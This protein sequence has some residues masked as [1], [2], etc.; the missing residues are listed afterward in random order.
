MAAREFHGVISNQWDTPIHWVQDDCDSGQ[1]QDPWYPSKLTG[2]GLINP[3]EDKEWRSESAGILTGTSGWSLWRINVST[4]TDTPHDEF[5]QV[6]W[7]IPFY[8]APNITY[9]VFRSDPRDAFRD[10]NPPVLEIIPVFW[11]EDGTESALA[12]AAEI[13]PY[14]FAIPVSFFFNVSFSTHPRIKFIV[15]QRAGAHVQ[16]PLVFEKSSLN[17][18]SMAMRAFQLRAEIAARNNFVGGFP[19]FYEATYGLDHVGG[20]IFV[21]ST[22]AEW[23]DVSVAELGNPSLEDFGE[24]MRATNAY[25]SRNGFV[26]GFPNFFHANYGSGIVCGTVLLNSTGA[27]WRD[28]PLSELGNPSLDD[29]ETRFRATQDYATRNG[30]V[31]GFPNLF[32][33]ETVEVSIVTGQRKRKT[34][35]GTILLKQSF[36]EWRDVLLFRGP[37]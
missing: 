25:A 9:S 13:A 8:G 32:H 12:Q 35:C 16:S 11:S 17:R 24:R 30:F 33:A 15:R 14:V 28:V 1:W 4:L 10:P 22:V 29:F 2:A 23:R 34:V 5:I 21:K 31:G 20:T 37:A 19:N 27:E 18:Q 36:A 26:G 7:S 3:G 6:N